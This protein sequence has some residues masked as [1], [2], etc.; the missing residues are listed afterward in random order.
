M[1]EQLSEQQLQQQKARAGALRT[2][3]RRKVYTVPQHDPTQQLQVI[4]AD[5]DFLTALKNGLNPIR[6]TANQHVV[7]LCT[8]YQQYT[9][10][11][12]LVRSFAKPGTDEHN[13]KPGQKWRMVDTMWD[14]VMATCN[15]APS[16]EVEVH[17]AYMVLLNKHLHVLLDSYLKFRQKSAGTK[18]D[19]KMRRDNLWDIYTTDL[20]IY[21]KVFKDKQFGELSGWL[22]EKLKQNIFLNNSEWQSF[23]ARCDKRARQNEVITSLPR[24]KTNH[25]N[26]DGIQRLA[27]GRIVG[28]FMSYNK[29]N[30]WVGSTMRVMRKL[31]PV[32]NRYIM[33]LFAMDRR[34]S[35]PELS[36]QLDE[37]YMVRFKTE[38]TAYYQLSEFESILTL[39]S[40]YNS[41]LCNGLKLT[42]S[43][44][45]GDWAAIEPNLSSASVYLEPYVHTVKRYMKF[46]FNLGCE[47]ENELM[48]KLSERDKLWVDG[49]LMDCEGEMGI[50]E[51]GALVYETVQTEPAIDSVSP[52]GRARRSYAERNGQLDWSRYMTKYK[53][54]NHSVPSGGLLFFD[55]FLK[56]NIS[57]TNV[58]SKI[59]HALRSTSRRTQILA[60]MG[61]CLWDITDK[62]REATFW[63][64]GSDYQTVRADDADVLESHGALATY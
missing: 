57:T 36:G 47:K 8:A 9:R 60:G 63:A 14:G 50:F 54:D 10:R 40:N 38:I 39:Q 59:C 22:K 49:A 52:F 58:Y 23:M 25:F 16:E 55:E 19:L 42:C 45:I 53:L 32:L 6:R 33:P 64:F 37:K 44:M 5:N 12:Q 21:I 26:D 28:T 41:D 34:W 51:R 35:A 4:P 1:S 24:W 29:S 11:A 17:S 31:F 30:S 56:Q 43:D 48:R 18:P 46:R 2:P 27:N 3:G 13:G 15:L 62:C 7:P 20:V 61:H